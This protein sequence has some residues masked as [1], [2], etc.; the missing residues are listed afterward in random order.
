MVAIKPT[1]SIFTGTQSFGR[2]FRE[3]NQINVKYA[4]INLPFSTTSGRLSGNVAGKTRIIMI[5]GAQDGTGYTGADA[6][7]RLK[8]FV[9]DM[10]GWIN[11]AIQTSKTFTN[12]FG[13]SYTVD[14]IDWSWV[15]SVGDPNR[16]IY[17]LIMK[18]TAL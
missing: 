5:Q 15:R 14:T 10:E 16:L 12:S 13:N 9:A 8:A 1:L 11:A 3:S 7:T 18:E 4:E 17:T 2:V 6:N